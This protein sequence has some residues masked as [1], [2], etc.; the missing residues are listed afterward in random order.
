MPI[1]TLQKIIK[2]LNDKTN[3]A[4][5]ALGA[6]MGSWIGLM[7]G[8]NLTT[9]L[10]FAVLCLL[11]ANLSMAILFIGFFKAIAYLADPWIHSLGFYF[12]T[13]IPA[14]KPV[15]TQLYNVPFVPFSRFNNTIVMGSFLLGLLLSP[16]LF[17]AVKHGV[18]FYRAKVQSQLARFKFFQLL[19]ANKIYE[20]Y[21]RFMESES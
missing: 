20:L 7:P 4:E 13:S 11:N 17:F 15:W 8:F 3:P 10:L 16:V 2:V 21:R 9:A 1:R 6:A 5:I 19:K 14:L 18:I 12:L